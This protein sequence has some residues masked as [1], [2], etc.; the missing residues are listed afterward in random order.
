L[1]RRA[2]L[3]LPPATFGPYF[4]TYRWNGHV[5]NLG[6][7]EGG[8]EGRGKGWLGFSKVHLK[9]EKTPIDPSRRV[10]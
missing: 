5:L 9:K 8:I 1:K 7:G 6:E 2:T 10:S 3:A 4:L